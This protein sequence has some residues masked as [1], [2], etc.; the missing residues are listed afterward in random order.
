MNGRRWAAILGLAAVAV[1][2]AVLADV[3]GD[4]TQ[5]RPESTL[6]GEVTV[7]Q[8][9][10]TTLDYKGDLDEA[11]AAAWNA[12]SGQAHGSADLH[13][14]A[15][16]RYEV[17]IAPAAGPQ[18]RHRVEGCIEDANTERVRAYLLSID[19]VPVDQVPPAPV[20]PA[21]VPPGPDA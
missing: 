10:V 16:D 12:C 21:P 1:S 7:I 4:A 18:A 14:L 8:M 5:T 20:P 6:D 15:D 17:R 11:A 3:V 2:L 9:R 13:H 19:N